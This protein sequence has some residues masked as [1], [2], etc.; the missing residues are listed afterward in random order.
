MFYPWDFLLSI[1][2]PPRMFEQFEWMIHFKYFLFRSSSFNRSGSY[3]NENESV[4]HFSYHDLMFG[5]FHKCNYRFP[6]SISFCCWIFGWWIFP[7]GFCLISGRLSCAMEF[8]M[9]INWVFF[10]GGKFLKEKHRNLNFSF[11]PKQRFLT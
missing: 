6:F 11:L 8:F 4:F 5:I 9:V 2:F 10:F 3:R 1:G 7:F